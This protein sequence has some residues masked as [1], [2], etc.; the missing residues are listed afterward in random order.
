ML[1]E[2]SG[3]RPDLYSWGQGFEINKVR[4]IHVDGLTVRET[5]GAAFNLQGP[6]SSAQMN[7][8]FKGVFADM[9][10]QDEDQAYDMKSD[11]Q[12]VYCKNVGGGWTFSGLVVTSP[13]GSFNGYLD[14]VKNASFAG[15]TWLRP[16]SSPYVSQVNGTS[17]VVGLP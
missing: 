2:G 14:N 15:T 12:V 4:G 3:N 8:S 6:D 17:G 13:S 5:R 9:R 10:V 1:I 11:A 7:W 16:G